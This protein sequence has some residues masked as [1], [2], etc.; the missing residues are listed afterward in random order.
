VQ[1]TCRLDGHELSGGVHYPG[2]LCVLPAGVQGQWNMEARADSLVMRLS[3]LLVKETAQTLAESNP[4]LCQHI[5]FEA[6]GAAP[7]KPRCVEPH[8]SHP[9]ESNGEI[10]F[11]LGERAYVENQGVDMTPLLGVGSFRGSRHVPPTVSLACQSISDAY[12]FNL[13][14]VICLVASNFLAYF[15]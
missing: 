5:S 9:Q 13:D 6:L 7:A 11:C 15:A 14:V 1:L 2:D 10:L 4:S 12:T 3:P 8:T